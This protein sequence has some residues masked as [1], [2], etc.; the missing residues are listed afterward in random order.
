M[1]TNSVARILAVH[2]GDQAESLMAN[3]RQIPAFPGGLDSGHHENRNPIAPA[4]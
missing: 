1:Q 4:A 3:L 2:N